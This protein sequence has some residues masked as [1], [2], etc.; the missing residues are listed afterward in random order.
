ME[1]AKLPLAKW[2]FAT[3]FMV[4]NKDGISAI[5]LAKYIDTYPRTAWAFLHKIRNAWG[6]VNA[7][8]SL[9]VL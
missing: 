2:F 3:Y 7:F 8:I 1:N 6:S 5:A 4:A 9:A